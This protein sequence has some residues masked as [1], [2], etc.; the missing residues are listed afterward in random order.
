MVFGLI[1][2][3]GNFYFSSENIIQSAILYDP[4]NEEVQLSDLINYNRKRVFGIYDADDSQW[5]YYEEPFYESSYGA[6]FETALVPGE[7]NLIATD[8]NG[9][10][11]ENSFNFDEQVNIPII[12]ASTFQ[13]YFDNS[14]NFICEWDIPKNIPN[15]LKTSAKVFIDAYTNDTCVALLSVK[16]PSHLGYIF[17]PSEIIQLLRTEGNVLKFYLQLGTNDNNNRSYSNSIVID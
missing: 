3:Y 8:K 2:L 9:N 11:Y 12:S 16:I 7:Y 14:G 17:V 4:D 15:D 10:S 5:I 6:Q 1:D 13:Y